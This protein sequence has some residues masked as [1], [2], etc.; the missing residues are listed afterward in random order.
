MSVTVKVEGLEKALKQIEALPD[1]LKK[2]TLLPAIRKGARLIVTAARQNAPRGNRRFR[3]S[4]GI[5]IAHKPG[6]L[7]RSI[8][9]ITTRATRKSANPSLIVGPRAG[10]KGGK[11]DG[12]Y[13]GWVEL[14]N[15][16]SAPR[17][18]M[19]RAYESEKDKVQ[20]L[21]SEEIGNAARKIGR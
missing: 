18:Y 10:K 2:K 12:Y 19:R 1:K 14:G 8:G 6:N 11:N 16:H 4:G 15:K 7:A 5:K 13:G 20:R 17:P 21:I 3:Y 9:I